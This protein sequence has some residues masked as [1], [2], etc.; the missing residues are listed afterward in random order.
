MVLTIS[1]KSSKSKKIR[2]ILDTDANNE[3]DDQHAI[4]YMLFN[5][6]IFDVE[7]ITINK[8]RNGG[9]IDDHYDEAERVV[10]LCGWHSKVELHKGATGSFDEIK[11][12]L[13]NPVFDGSDAVNFIISMANKKSNRK[14]V[15]LAIG[16]LTNIAIL[17]L[18]LIII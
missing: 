2:I 1:Q 8:T 14:L 16:K 7:G 11:Y 3:L 13:N 18:I 5:D 4:A 15:L 9:S 12:Q 10:K 6:S 17:L